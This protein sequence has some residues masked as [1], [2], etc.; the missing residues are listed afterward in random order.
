MKKYLIFRTDRVGDFLLTLSL[1]KIIKT[2]QPQSIITVIA[3][4]SNSEYIESFEEVD[5]VI[6][7]KNNL[8]SKIKLILRLRKIKYESIIV[9]DGKKRSRFVSFF[10]KFKKRIVCFNNLI[11]SQI[12][13]IKKTCEKINLN[14]NNDCLD[15]LDKRNHNIVNIPF[16]NYILLHFD[17]K[18]KHNEYIEKYTNIEP[19]EKE[20]L[21]FINNIISKNKNLIITSGKK[22][23]TILHNIQNKVDQKKIQIFLDQNLLEIENIVFKCDLLI[24]CH[25][26]ISH[27]ASAKKIH[28]IDIIDDLYPYHKWTSHFRN[29]ISI[30]RELFKI[31]SEK[32]IDLI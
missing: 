18:W 28:Q 21:F 15:F 5:D 26:W 31:L 25:G 22:S 30:K 17:E 19:D 27:I 32:I 13:I 7:L 10:L 29:Y 3:S 12:E 11:D 14:F 9:H 6:I 20:L 24:T 2:N 8:L 1:I 4:K 23:P 16:K